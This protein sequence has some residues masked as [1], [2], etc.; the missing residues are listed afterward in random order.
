M[1]MQELRIPNDKHLG[2][3][4]Q[5]LIFVIVLR[6]L[7]TTIRCLVLFD[8]VLRDIILIFSCENIE[9]ILILKY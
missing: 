6:K 3:G 7:Q 2:I 4:V 8:I 9:A 1:C 5:N